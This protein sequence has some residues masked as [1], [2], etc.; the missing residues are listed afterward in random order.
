M[1][2]LLPVPFHS[3]DHLRVKQIPGSTGKDRKKLFQTVG[4]ELNAN[5]R[6][7]QSHY[8]RNNIYPGAPEQIGE[9]RG[10]AAGKPDAQAHQNYFNSEDKRMLR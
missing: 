6:H 9:E 8:S 3:G 4:N 1:I 5:G 10:G 2:G 7:D